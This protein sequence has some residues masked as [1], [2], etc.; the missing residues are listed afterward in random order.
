[1]ALVNI[2][3]AFTLTRFIDVAGISLATGLAGWVQCFFLWRGQRGNEAVAFDARLKRTVPRIALCAAV[4]AL[5]LYGVCRGL[6]SWFFGAQAERLAALAVLMGT[7]AATYFGSAHATG[8]L[9]FQDLKKYLTRRVR[10]NPEMIEE[11]SDID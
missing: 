6:E 8:V 4:M 10:K 2:A 7:G 5:A 1:M 11:V 3:V 9:K